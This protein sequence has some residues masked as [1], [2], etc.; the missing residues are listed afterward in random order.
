MDI[1]GYLLPF[2]AA[3]VVFAVA[4]LLLDMAV[5]NMQGLSLIFHK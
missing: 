5:M 3:L 4:F 1:K 2:A